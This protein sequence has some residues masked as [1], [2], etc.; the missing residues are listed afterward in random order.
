M[1]S[2]YATGKESGTPGGHGAVG[3]AQGQGVDAAVFSN[4][5]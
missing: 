1:G 2:R 3:D 4:F 5:I